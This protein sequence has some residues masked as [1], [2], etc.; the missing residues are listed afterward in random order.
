VSVRIPRDTI[1]EDV[2]P[3]MAEY[4]KHIRK[5][6]GGDND[7]YF[8]YSDVPIFGALVDIHETATRAVL[9]YYKLEC[10]QVVTPI[11]NIPLQGLLKQYVSRLRSQIRSIKRRQI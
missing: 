4:L 1:G 3:E 5:L 10:G 6:C 7:F 11:T 2:Y 9:T 8:R